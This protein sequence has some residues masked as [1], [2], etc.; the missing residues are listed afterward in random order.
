MNQK[1]KQLSRAALILAGVM[2]MNAAHADLMGSL[3]SA[4]E[5]LSSSSANTSTGASSTSLL[6]GALGSLM[7]GNSQALQSTSSANIGGVL[8]YCVQNNVLAAGNQKIE[9]VK[10]SLLNKLGTQTESE[11]YQNG[12]NGILDLQG[13]DDVDLNNL[14]SLTTDMKAKIKTKVCGMV[15][16]QAKKF[17]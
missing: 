10:D 13:K 14:G 16:D 17:V 6:G 12:L 1:L 5:Q 15:L 8:S 4:S 3:K 11:S 9:S 2:G 7:G